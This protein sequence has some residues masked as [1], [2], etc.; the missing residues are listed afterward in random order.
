MAIAIF[1]KLA[2]DYMFTEDL[3]TKKR[4]GKPL[5]INF[6]DNDSSHLSCEID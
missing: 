3:N 5:T 6:D 2:W 1:I 4:E